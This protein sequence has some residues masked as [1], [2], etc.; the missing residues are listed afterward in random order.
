M[1][2]IRQKLRTS[3]V[4]EN[5]TGSRA[6]LPDSSRRSSRGSLQR[7][8]GVDSFMAAPAS[9]ASSRENSARTYGPPQHGRGPG[10]RY[11]MCAV[12][13][14]KRRPGYRLSARCFAGWRL[15]M[16][17]LEVKIEGEQIRLASAM[18]MNLLSIGQERSATQ[19]KHGGARLIRVETA[20]CALPSVGLSRHR[21]MARVRCHATVAHRALWWCS[22]TMR[23]RA[24]SYGQRVEI[25]RRKPPH[26]LGPA[27]R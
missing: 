6:K 3:A 15:A 26:E 17:R 22:R 16:A 25:I 2:I 12:T 24:K 23:E 19:W 18:D 4:L 27:S 8:Y 20:L 11:G 21:T 5:E 10:A 13:C 7:I 9:R 14:S 1:E